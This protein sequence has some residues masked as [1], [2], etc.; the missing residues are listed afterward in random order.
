[1]KLNELKNFLSLCPGKD[2]EI[3]VGG[4]NFH[5]DVTEMGRDIR[6]FLDCGGFKRSRE[7]CVLQTWVGDDVDHSLSSTALLGILE[8]GS[9]LF[10]HDIPEVWVEI[11]WVLRPISSVIDADVV[12]LELG[13]H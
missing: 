9:S 11:D 1:M 12:V 10:E 6:E 5:F 2:V 8:K 13:N 7:R 4:S 3:I